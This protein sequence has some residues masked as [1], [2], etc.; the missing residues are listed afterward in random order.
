MVPA[1]IAQGQ[2]TLRQCQQHRAQSSGFRLSK[3][4]GFQGKLVKLNCL[5]LNPRMSL[6]AW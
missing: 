2:R 1:R 4:T 6:L 3:K 5:C